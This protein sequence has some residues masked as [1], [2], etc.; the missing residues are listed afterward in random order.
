MHF[1]AAPHIAVGKLW[2]TKGHLS[3]RVP[4]FIVR[5]R[6]SPPPCPSPE[7]RAFR[8]TPHHL[9]LFFVLRPLESGGAGSLHGP[10]AL[11]EAPA[12]RQV[13]SCLPSAA[14]GLAR[15]AS[16]SSRAGILGPLTA[17]QTPAVNGQLALLRPLR[18]RGDE[19]A[20]LTAG[21]KQR[22]VSP[23]EHQNL[24]LQGR[25]PEAGGAGDSAQALGPPAPRSGRS[26]TDSVPLHFHYQPAGLRPL[27][28]G[29][30][31][32]PP[33]GSGP[34]ASG[35]EL[36][37]KLIVPSGKELVAPQL[38]ADPVG[39]GR[40]RS[41]STCRRGVVHAGSWRV[42]S[43]HEMAWSRTRRSRH[44]HRALRLLRVAKYQ[45]PLHL[46]LRDP[47]VAGART[48]PSQ[49]TPPQT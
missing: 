49:R 28:E 35:S 4:A 22:P 3:G 2:G 36:T 25:H 24:R 31:A 1:P 14:G 41:S 45:G 20:F 6:V 8:A 27:R 10:P 17:G 11:G 23:R 34:P 44:P 37:A 43:L 32:E 29:L 21:T 7:L 42:L 46:G 48:R 38:C 40:L 16:G 30:C 39:G 9:P 5:S 33:R 18:P 13:G 47:G 26:R 19:D 15:G 12:G